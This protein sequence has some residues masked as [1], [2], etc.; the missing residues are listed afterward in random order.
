MQ[1][2]ERQSAGGLAEHVQQEP[3]PNDMQAT[4]TALMSRHTQHI[5][6]LGSRPPICERSTLKNTGLQPDRPSQTAAIEVGVPRFA[7]QLSI[8]CFPEPTNWS[9]KKTSQTENRRQRVHNLLRCH[10]VL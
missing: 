9:V 5:F 3:E 1:K 6:K 7:S 2:L 10:S 4:V 8:E